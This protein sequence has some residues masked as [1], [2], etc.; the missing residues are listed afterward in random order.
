MMSKMQI[1]LPASS[2]PFFNRFGPASRDL[3]IAAALSATF[4]ILL[5]LIFNPRWESNDD[6]AMSMVAH[7]YGIASQGS[8]RLIFSNVLWGAIVRCIPSI[9]GLLGYSIATLLAMTLAGAATLYFLLRISVGYFVGPLVFVLV[10]SRP[11][12]VPQFTITAGLLAVAAVLGLIAYSRGG[13]RFNL[14]AASCLGF[15][16]Y[17]I[18]APEFALV[19]GV[20]APLLPWRK[21]VRDRAAWL[22]ASAVVVCIAGAAIIDVWAYSGSEWQA[23][24]QGNLARA[25]F[26]DFGAVD[27]VLQHSDTMQRLGLSENDIR[28][29]GSYFFADQRL[30]NPKLLSTLLGEIPIETAS[31]TSFASGWASVWS[32]FGPELLPLAMTGFFLM[33]LFARP[34]QVVAWMICLAAMFAFGA[35]GRPGALRIYIPLFSLFIVIACAG[36]IL[37]SRWRCGAVVVVLFTGCLMNARQLSSETATSDWMV[38]HAVRKFVSHESTVVWGGSLPIEYIFPVFTRAADVRDTRIYGLGAFTR[39][40]FSVAFADERA[41]KGLLARLR[42]EAGIPLIATSQLQAQLNTYCME[43]YGTALRLSVIKK[44]ELWT[45]MNASCATAEAVQSP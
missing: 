5:C 24:W 44:L 11:V 32:M 12:L 3:F 8:F 31:K 43:H 2:T 1:A 10:F 45:E 25:P 13:S 23:F 35:L 36:A 41:G 14:I 18:R 34:G 40:P 29:I 19:G 38:Q 33:L 27:L 20:A 15:L 26:T 6:V 22:A 37:Q 4:V 39:A 42:S 21:L 9:D 16:A 28:L 7:G 30:A 17:L